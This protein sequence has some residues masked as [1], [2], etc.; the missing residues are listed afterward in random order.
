MNGE[1]IPSIP[2]GYYTDRSIERIALPPIRV[3]ENVITVTLPFGER[4]GPEWCYLLGDFG[5]KVSGTE[6]ILIP[7]TERMGYEDIT[8]EGYPFYGGAFTYR[9]PFEATGGEVALTV[10][11]YRGAVMSILL[12]GSELGELAYPP[13]RFSLGKVGAGKHL[14]EIRLYVSRQNAFGHLHH[15]DATLSWVGPNAWRSKD[16]AWTDCY[17]LRPEGILSA[18]ILTESF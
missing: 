12:D 10:P 8:R 13:Y 6:K 16:A 17:R 2:S 7:R 11:H 14:L 1:R 15:A 18:P 4:I 5:V 9:I 3:G